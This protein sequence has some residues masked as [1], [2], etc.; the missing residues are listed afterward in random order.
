MGSI[1]QKQGSIC[2]QESTTKVPIVAELKRDSLQVSNVKLQKKSLV[3]V[4][5]INWRPKNRAKKKLRMNM[6]RILNPKLKEEKIT[7][8]EDSSTEEDMESEKD[9][10]PQ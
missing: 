4:E 9:L 1:K 10:I 5:E 3:Q 2:V 6:K 7:V 8:I